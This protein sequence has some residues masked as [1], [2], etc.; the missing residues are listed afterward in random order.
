LFENF[1][2]TYV[3]CFDQTYPISFSS[4]PPYPCITTI[5]MHLAL[6]PQRPL[7][8]YFQLRIFSVSFG[9]FDHKSIGV[10]IFYLTY[11][12]RIINS[13]CNTCNRAIHIQLCF[14]KFLS[15]KTIFLHLLCVCVLVCVYMCVCECVCVSVCMC[16]C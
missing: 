8:I 12:L 14:N 1:S 11:F 9:L 6:N 7:Q 16:V 3:V 4:V 10:C 15:F 13:T 5:F 2:Y